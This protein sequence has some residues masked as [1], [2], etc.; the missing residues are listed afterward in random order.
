[1]GKSGLGF[2]PRNPG[3]ESKWN[4]FQALLSHLVKDNPMLMDFKTSKDNFW[5][6]SMFPVLVMEKFAWSSWKQRKGKNL[7]QV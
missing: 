2:G 3:S 6:M 4:G 1:M 5:S 7:I